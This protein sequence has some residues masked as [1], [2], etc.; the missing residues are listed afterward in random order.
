MTYYAPIKIYKPFSVDSLCPFRITEQLAEMVYHERDTSGFVQIRAGST[1]FEMPEAVHPGD[2]QFRYCLTQVQFIQLFPQHTCILFLLQKCSR[3]RPETGITIYDLTKTL[4]MIADYLR[5]HYINRMSQDS[6]GHTYFQFDYKT[7]PAPQD[8][9]RDAEAIRATRQS[10]RI[11]PPGRPVPQGLNN[12]ATNYINRGL[13]IEMKKYF[14]I[15]ASNVYFVPWGEEDEPSD[16]DIRVGKIGAYCLQVIYRPGR[17]DESAPYYTALLHLS[18]DFIRQLLP[19]L[20]KA[21]VQPKMENWSIE[22]DAAADFYPIVMAYWP[23]ISVCIATG[24]NRCQIIAPVETESIAI[25][26]PLIKA[27]RLTFYRSYET[28]DTAFTPVSTPEIML[29]PLDGGCQMRKSIIHCIRKRWSSLVVSAMFIN[30]DYIFEPHPKVRE[31]LADVPQVLYLTVYVKTC[32]IVN[33]GETTRITLLLDPAEFNSQF[34]QCRGW[35]SDIFC[36]NLPFP[37][38]PTQFIDASLIFWSRPYQIVLD[39][40]LRV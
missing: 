16:Y 14:E 31:I 11:L 9:V 22:S 33:R 19:M 38:G 10:I 36:Q 24:T 29:H 30:Q 20:P 1:I 7:Y 3:F 37:P 17:S 5:F 8:R 23:L 35:E 18:M 25:S 13:Y 2:E 34:P 32:S 27:S 12:I 4:V 39:N 21:F 26:E 28:T 40:L 15:P 6:L